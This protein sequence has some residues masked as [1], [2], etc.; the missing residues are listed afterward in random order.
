MHMTRSLS[1]SRKLAR[2]PS[3]VSDAPDG[4]GAGEPGRS[5]GRVRYSGLKGAALGEAIMPIQSWWG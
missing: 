4:K 1:A 3:A 2:N 5:G